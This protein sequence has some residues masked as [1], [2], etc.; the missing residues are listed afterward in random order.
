MSVL[1]QLSAKLKRYQEDVYGQFAKECLKDI[2]DAERVNENHYTSIHN[3]TLQ[4]SDQASA[5]LSRLIEEKKLSNSE[6]AEV[7]NW[8]KNRIGDIRRGKY[9]P[10]E[11]EVAQICIALGLCEI[12]SQ[13][14]LAVFHYPYNVLVSLIDLSLHLVINSP[15]LKTVQ[16][17]LMMYRSM[18]Q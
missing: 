7:L 13:K 2:K 17:R 6:L 14:L 11:D 3:H 1:D 18:T 12:A 8:G 9:L 15:V 4:Y 10:S 5:S 16:D